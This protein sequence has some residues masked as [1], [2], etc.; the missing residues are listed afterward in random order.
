M[1]A[2]MLTA[3]NVIC[4]NLSAM[5]MFRL[6]GVG[7]YTVLDSRRASKGSTYAMMFW[8]LLLALLVA[9]IVAWPSII[10]QLPGGEQLKEDA[11]QTV[12]SESDRAL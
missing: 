10:E 5:A 9:I 8:A 4:I 1:G 3:T 7:P 6:Q 2:L 12:R 11:E